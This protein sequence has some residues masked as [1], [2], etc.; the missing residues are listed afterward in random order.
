MSNPRHPFTFR[1]SP[2]RL[3]HTP[4]QTLKKRKSALIKRKCWGH[5][6]QGSVYGEGQKMRQTRDSLNLFMPEKFSL[7]NQ[8]LTSTTE[9]E[10]HLRGGRQ[11][12]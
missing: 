3:H 8:V 9:G 2:T 6:A 1:Y 10:S 11:S 4:I 7:G 12:S 5:S